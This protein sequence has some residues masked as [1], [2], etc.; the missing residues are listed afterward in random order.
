MA[1]PDWIEY[2]NDGAFRQFAGRMAAIAG[3]FH[4]IAGIFA[5]LRAIFFV[6]RNRAVAGGVSAFLYLGHVKTPSRSTSNPSSTRG[7]L[8]ANGAMMLVRAM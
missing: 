2:L 4:L 8:N 5:I 6:L 3:D 7:T 1:Q